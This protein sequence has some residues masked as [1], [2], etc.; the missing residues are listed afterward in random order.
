MRNQNVDPDLVYDY[1]CCSSQSSTFGTSDTKEEVHIYRIDSHN[2]CICIS[3][4]EH[5]RPT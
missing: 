4:Y 2:V 1:S 3:E 5:I